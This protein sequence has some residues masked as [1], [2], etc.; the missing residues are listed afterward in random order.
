LIGIGHSGTTFC[1]GNAH[2]FLEA[3][4]N[5]PEKLRDLADL[6]VRR[7]KVTGDREN[8]PGG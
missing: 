5:S 6:D 8:R 2:Q 4:L 3:V 7:R 1:P